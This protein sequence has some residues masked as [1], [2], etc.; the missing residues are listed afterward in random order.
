MPP[1]NH[2]AMMEKPVGKPP[3]WKPRLVKM[4][5]PTMLAMTMQVAVSSEMDFT[6]EE[7]APEFTKRAEGLG[8]ACAEVKQCA[9]TYGAQGPFLTFFVLTIRNLPAACPV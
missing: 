4:P 2:S 7:G 3:T 1:M 9:E 6:A 5:V 8:K